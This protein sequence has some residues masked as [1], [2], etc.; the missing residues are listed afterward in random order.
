MWFH[1]D[2]SSGVPIYIQLIEQVKKATA[3]GLLSKGEQ[4]PSVR[5]MAVELTVNPNTIAKAYQ[6]LEREGIIETLRGRGTFV[7]QKITRLDDRDK[8]Q[9]LHGSI[10]KLLIEA[11]HLQVPKA[12]IEKIFNEEINKWFKSNGGVF[13]V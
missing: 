4:L 8:K 3:S 1:I 2:P 7:A 6:E 13:N 5:D 10:Q 9:V 12:D 11:H